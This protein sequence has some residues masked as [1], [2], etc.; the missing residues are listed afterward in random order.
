MV[1]QTASVTWKTH[2]T[3]RPKQDRDTEQR[4][5]Y[6]GLEVIIYRYGFGSLH[7]TINGTLDGRDVSAFDLGYDRNLSDAA[8]RRASLAFADRLLE[9]GFG[10][11]P[12]H[13]AEVPSDTP[14]ALEDDVAG[15]AVS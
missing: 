5:V 8:L 14:L 7:V 13:V 6:R 15:E 4:A 10:P 2:T 3:P 1:T 12:R 9:I 11:L